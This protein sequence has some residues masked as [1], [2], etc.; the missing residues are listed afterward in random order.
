MYSGGEIYEMCIEVK[1]NTMNSVAK[2]MMW[3][4]MRCEPLNLYLCKRSENKKQSKK[5]LNVVIRKLS[6]N[7]VTMEQVSP[8]QSK[9]QFP[10]FVL[11]SPMFGSYFYVIANPTV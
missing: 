8:F 2:I 9:Y 6:F 7:A 4:S 1:E 10:K 3:I 11:G 5:I